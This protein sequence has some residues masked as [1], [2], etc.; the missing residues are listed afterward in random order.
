MKNVGCLY[1][2]NKYAG[3]V[4]A[5]VDTSHCHE[6]ILTRAAANKISGSSCP[7]INRFLAALS[8]GTH[9]EY[10]Y[11]CSGLMRVSNAQMIL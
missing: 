11:N 1:T 10:Q 8:N 2:G 4:G 3:K 5:K 9:D 7:K 6:M